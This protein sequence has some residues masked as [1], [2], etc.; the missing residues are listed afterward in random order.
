VDALLIKVANF[1]ET[2][3][4]VVGVLFVLEFVAVFIYIYRTSAADEEEGRVVTEQMRIA[5]NPV[6]GSRFIAGRYWSKRKVLFSRSGSTSAYM[7]LRFVV[8]CQ[9]DPQEPSRCAA[10][11]RRKAGAA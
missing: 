6:G 4:W 10:R 7:E 5:G 9:S 1:S 8:R 2:A 11:I 3:V